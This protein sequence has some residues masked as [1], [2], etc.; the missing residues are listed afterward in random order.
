MENNANAFVESQK[1]KQRKKRRNS[2][3]V[4][5]VVMLVVVTAIVLM[6]RA[7]NAQAASMSMLTYNAESI[8]E[9]EVTS[10]ISGSGTLTATQSDTIVSAAAVRVESV[11]FSPGDA[12][13]AGELIM[14]LSSEE[15]EKQLDALYDELDNLQSAIAGTTRE[16]TNLNV[17]ATKKGVVKD[18][19]AGTRDVAE[20]LDYLCLIA[21]DGKMKLAID[22]P[23][24]MKQYDTV[25]VSV[26]GAAAALGSVTDIQKGKATVVFED[27]GYAVGAAAEALDE[28]GRLLGSGRITV[29]DHVAIRASAGRIAS[30]EAA[31]ENKTVSKGAVLF[32]L[33]DG[34]P[35]ES[36]KTRKQQERSL[37]ERIEELE[38]QLTITA[39][40]DCILAYLPVEAGDELGAAATLCTLSGTGGYSMSL[41]IDELDIAS[42]KLGQDVS[43]TLD[44][45]DGVFTGKVTNI[46]YAGSGSYVTSYTVTVTTDA[47]EG[48]LPGMSA[49]VEIVTE[50]SGMSLIVSAG[51]LQYEG[52]KAFVYRCADGVSPGT[53]LGEAELDLDSLEKAYVETGMSNGS[54]VVIS[55][56]GLSAS[57]LIWVPNRTTLS[58]YNPNATTNFGFGG[59]MRV[60]TV[61]EYTIDSYPGGSM[62]Q[63]PEGGGY[64]G[65]N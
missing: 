39:D 25:Y 12:V 29:N 62:G 7:L 23:A 9:G 52:D 48:A 43:V 37:L 38:K 13:K 56:E 47:I 10:A 40:Y 44:A 18:V 45:L 27:D 34:A 22:A 17:T 15:L 42:V 19:Q 64:P 46:S 63:R 41:S 3:I 16:L 6:L 35:T 59:G 32:T 8:R 57:D 24:G 55:G 30:I 65:G 60:D 2:L 33:V 14:T 49:S 26:D 28:G 1:K 61:E 21:T 58:T 5:G 36:Y 31:L 51:A 11:K 53:V 20:E 50:T 54:Y 4:L